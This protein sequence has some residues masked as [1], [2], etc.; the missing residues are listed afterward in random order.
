ML[1]IP[2][3]KLDDLRKTLIEDEGEDNI[4]PKQNN[5][6]YWSSCKCNVSLT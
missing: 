3:S 2:V 4:T 6:D 5:N 1:P